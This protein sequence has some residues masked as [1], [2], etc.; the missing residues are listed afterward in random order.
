MPD[1]T[2]SKTSQRQPQ[3]EGAHE[4]ARQVTLSGPQA[5]VLGLQRAAGNRAV[6]GLL[7]SAGQQAPPIV[8]DVL[9]SGGQPLEPD[10]RADMEQRFG[11]DFGL[12]RVHTDARAAES[13][14]AVQ[15]KAY[16]VGQDVVFDRGKFAPETQVGMKLLAHEL[17]HTLQN[18]ESGHA[19]APLRFR[20]RQGDAAEQQAQE[21]SSRIIT[22]RFGST[23]SMPFVTPSAHIQAEDIVPL[24]NPDAYL[25]D[26]AELNT[27]MAGKS[28]K[29]RVAFITAL[30]N[31]VKATWKQAESVGLITMLDKV[32]ATEK[33]SLAPIPGLDTAK[34]KPQALRERLMHNAG[35][36]TPDIARD[37]ETML[38][39]QL[40]L[41]SKLVDSVVKTS[42]AAVNA[43]MSLRRL[44]DVLIRILS[45]RD[46]AQ[47]T[48]TPLSS[49]LAMY[50]VEGDMNVPPSY[51][52]LRQAIPPGI[53]DATT[54]LTLRPDISRLVWLADSAKLTKFGLTTDSRIKEVALVE[55]FVQIGGLDQVGGLPEP[56]RKPFMDWSS[57][58]WLKAVG[59]GEGKGP[60]EAD[61]IAEAR[62]DAAKRW[63]TL[64]ATMNLE[65]KSGLISVAVRVTPS[66]PQLLISGI[67]QEAVMLQRAY[68]K[69]SSL[70]SKPA[71]A[72][73]GKTTDLTPG[74]AYLHFHAGDDREN[75][76]RILM[77]ALIAA[78]SAGGSRFKELR[79]VKA[80]LNINELKDKSAK[81]DV[82]EKVFRDPLK[83]SVQ[84]AAAEQEII[85]LAREMWILV[86]PWLEAD[87]N[88]LTLLSDFIETAGTD[89]WG[90]WQDHRENLSRYNIL[91]EYYE[92]L[93]K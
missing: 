82:Q 69:V 62:N 38:G 92:R 23:A 51:M 39:Q 85:R 89:V 65:R 24:G 18:A 52:S 64:L 41:G 14:R 37:T 55:W 21:A 12:V 20:S 28:S 84:K 29:D 53:T 35:H 43:V 88:R 68:S 48:G 78:S 66:D 91:R 13:A 16:T 93:A 73:A 19:T 46:A 79:K 3:A 77:S 40:V 9:R 6:D 1:P 27:L 47:A 44:D 86:S 70:L 30:L 10:T 15:A 80:F 87:A 34:S 67:L 2:H 5:A 7:G 90:G 74:M 76:R 42:D 11:E 83:T 54:H 63:D 33:S 71:K 72:V 49:V 81:I 45:T 8:G 50:R 75:T 59:A 22:G 57:N 61:L 4:Q 36:T 17:V 32:R 58:N 26:T 56:R 60:A 31:N 25:P